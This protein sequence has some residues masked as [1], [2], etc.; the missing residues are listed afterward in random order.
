M[1]TGCH[2]VCGGHSNFTANGSCS[3]SQCGGAQC[4]DDRG[5]RVCGGE[6]CNGTLSTSAAAL[7][8]ARIVNDSL[9]AVNEGLQTVSR[10]VLKAVTHQ[11]VHWKQRAVVYPPVCHDTV[12]SITVATIQFLCWPGILV[13]CIQL[14]DIAT[15]TNDVK[16]QAMTTL[17]KAQMKKDDFEKNNKELKDFIQ[18]I[19]DFLTGTL[20]SIVIWQ[21]SK[22]G[23][24]LSGLNSLSASPPFLLSRG[25]R[26]STEHRNSGSAGLVHHAAGEQQ[27]R[28]K[29]HHADKGQPLQPHQHGGSHQRNLAAHKQSKGAA[30]QR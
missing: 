12:C 5:N 24:Q 19:R 17:K 23:S 27:H 20:N 14:Q 25:R 16:N 7:N 21:S 8:E 1:W 15:M 29:H 3:D 2:Q 4:R 28:G 13:S 9:S 11:Y 30:R 26:R 22:K 10:K 18:K 6:G